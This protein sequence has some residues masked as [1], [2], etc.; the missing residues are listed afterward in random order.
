MKPQ[1]EYVA[2]RGMRQRC[3]SPSSAN[4]VNYGGR[5]IKVCKRWDSFQMF[6]SDMGHK[7]TEAHS[8]DRID[9]ERDYTPDNCRWATRSQQTLNTRVR[10]NNI[11]GLAGVSWDGPRGQWQV[12]FQGKYLGR[13]VDFF[14]ACCF[15]KSA[16]L[17][18][19]QAV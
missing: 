12:R 2:W 19:T 5:G 14:E 4:Y 13:S 7:P 11:S 16:E 18:K 9:N 6:L 10:I 15:R 3:N 17:N 8:L 1:A